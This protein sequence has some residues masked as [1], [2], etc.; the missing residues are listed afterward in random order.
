MIN[1]N[2]IGV[3]L[4][5]V[6][7]GVALC[8]AS[9]ILAYPFCLIEESNKHKLVERL[10]EIVEKKQITTAVVGLPKNM[11]GSLGKSA[12]YVKNIFHNFKRSV[13]KEIEF[14]LWDERLSTASTIKNFNEAKI[15]G[16][17]RKKFVDSF[18]A[19]NILQNYLDFKHSFFNKGS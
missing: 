12:I 1:L 16:K 19:S 10:V 5:L 7:T 17:K 13:K 2:L 4:G 8:D 9:E 3:D 18:S 14:I 15:F 6:R 11:D